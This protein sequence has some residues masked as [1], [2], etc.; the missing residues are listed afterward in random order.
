MQAKKKRFWSY[1]HDEEGTLT[2]DLGEFDSL[3]E[4]IDG[5]SNWLWSNLE[6]AARLTVRVV[7]NDLQDGTTVWWAGPKALEG[8]DDRTT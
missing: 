3:T 2:G 1:V 5:V 4:A 7:D 6:K 8:I